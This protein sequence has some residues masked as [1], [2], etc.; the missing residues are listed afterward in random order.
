MNCAKRDAL[1]FKTAVAEKI[2][3]FENTIAESLNKTMI[4]LFYS[5]DILEPI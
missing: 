3:N 5:G 2:G 4:F 1:L